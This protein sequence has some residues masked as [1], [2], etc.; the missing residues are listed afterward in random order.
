MRH[1]GEAADGIWTLQVADLQPL[2][3]GRFVRWS[4]RIHGR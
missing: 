4:L 3:T 2:D 1:L